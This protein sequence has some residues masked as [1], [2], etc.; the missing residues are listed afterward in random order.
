MR[1]FRLFNLLASSSYPVFFSAVIIQTGTRYLIRSVFQT[2][3]A[4]M[5]MSVILAQKSVQN[6][7]MTGAAVCLI[8]AGFPEMILGYLL[9]MTAE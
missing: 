8:M 6:Q 2:M 4:L 9:M 5:A 3:I 7:E 1:K